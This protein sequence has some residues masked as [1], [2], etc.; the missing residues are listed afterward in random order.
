MV[1]K[2]KINKKDKTCHDVTL[3]LYTK[4]YNITTLQMSAHNMQKIN[5][6]TN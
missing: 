1:T 4:Y 5:I 3:Q 2:L 6:C